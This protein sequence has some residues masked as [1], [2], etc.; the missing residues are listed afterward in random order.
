M[1]LGPAVC[2]GICLERIFRK[3]K[4][5]SVVGGLL[6]N[7]Q[8][9]LCFAESTPNQLDHQGMESHTPLSTNFHKSMHA[10]RLKS[11]RM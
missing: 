11:S 10:A 9:Y 5:Q 2:Q 1:T 4:S 3:G 7:K 6:G 8:I